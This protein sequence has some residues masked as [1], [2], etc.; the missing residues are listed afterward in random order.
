LEKTSKII[1]SNR[2]PNPT[3][4]AKPCYEVP[5]LHVFWRPPGGDGDS[6]TSLGSLF[7]CLTTLSAKNTVTTLYHNAQAARDLNNYMKLLL[8]LVV[9]NFHS[10]HCN[11]SKT[12]L[13]DAVC[14]QLAGIK[15]CHFTN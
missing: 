13:S 4:P 14:F 9:Y 6:T 7:P 15:S 11:L 8:F 3:M 10:C 1:K 2:H 12:H 5:H